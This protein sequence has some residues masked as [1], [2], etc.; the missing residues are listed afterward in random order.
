M[1]GRHDAWRCYYTFGV[2]YQFRKK[3]GF[4]NELLNC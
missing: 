3:L 4:Y 2:T 1:I